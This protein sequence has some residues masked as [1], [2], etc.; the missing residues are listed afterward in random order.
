MFAAQRILLSSLLHEKVGRDGGTPEKKLKGCLG[1]KKE[2]PDT[3]GRIER[4][5]LTSLTT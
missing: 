4:R 3:I 1:E 5:V 2:S